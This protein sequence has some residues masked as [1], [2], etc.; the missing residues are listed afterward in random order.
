MFQIQCEASKVFQPYLSQSELLVV[1]CERCIPYASQLILSKHAPNIPQNT[2]FFSLP[3]YKKQK[4]KAKQDKE[5]QTKGKIF[6]EW[7]EGIE[8]D[9]KALLSNKANMWFENHLPW[10]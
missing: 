4:K 6:W 1:Y 2:H 5:K 7:L 10:I 8:K 3:K 9:L